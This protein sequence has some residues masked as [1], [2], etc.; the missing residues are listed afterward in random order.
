[1]SA[2]P[3]VFDPGLSSASNRTPFHAPPDHST[4][5]TTTRHPVQ[6]KLN[7]SRIQTHL[8]QSRTSFLLQWLPPSCQT[9]CFYS[10]GTMLVFP[11]TNLVLPTPLLKKTSPYVYACS[12]NIHL[13]P[14]IDTPSND[15][16]ITTLHTRRLAP[17]LKIDAFLERQTRLLDQMT[18]R[19]L[20][21]MMNKAIQAPHDSKFDMTTTTN[22]MAPLSD[23]FSSCSASLIDNVRMQDAAMTKTTPKATYPPSDLLFSISS[24][25]TTTLGA[26]IVI[27]KTAIAVRP[28]RKPPHMSHSWFPL[29][30]RAG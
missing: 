9:S 26:L 15:T 13:T 3:V 25:P 4:H 29:P 30:N 21:H 1:M 24:T 8:S 14:V 22:D 5:L 6:Q 28:P 7:I 12:R 2:I 16:I 18:K 20:D 17:D 23:D 11:S 10:V 19:M 27:P